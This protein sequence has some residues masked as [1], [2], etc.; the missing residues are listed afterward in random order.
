MLD[1]TPAFRVSCSVPSFTYLAFIACSAAVREWA[2]CKC[3]LQTLTL[4]SVLP[5]TWHKQTSPGLSVWWEDLVFMIH[6][7][8]W[9]LINCLFM[10]LVTLDT[11]QQLGMM[12][13][14]VN[15]AIDPFIPAKL[16]NVWDVASD[17]SD[18]AIGIYLAGHI[19]DHGN[20][21]S[22]A[23]APSSGHNPLVQL[24]GHFNAWGNSFI[25]MVNTWT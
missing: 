11:I 19:H 17:A 22:A 3:S 15:L 12:S 4:L 1:T 8:F 16:I 5:S 14:R 6:S 2:K 23:Y 10:L 24:I 13:L 20:L 25:S 18:L 9:S 21:C 7:Y